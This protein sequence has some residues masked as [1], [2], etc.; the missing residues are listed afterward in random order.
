MKK[1]LI[2]SAA[3]ALS[4]LMVAASNWFEEQTKVVESINRQHLHE[5]ERLKK[6]AKINKWLRSTITPF[7]ESLPKDANASDVTLVKFFDRY[8]DRFDFRVKNYIYK[9]K[10]SH[11]LD[12]MFKIPR[13]D[14]KNLQELMLLR[15]P[16]GYLQY[17]T[18]ELKE[19]SVIGKLRIVQPLY[20]DFN[21]SNR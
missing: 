16:T 20:G 8:A 5:I 18:F 11:N 6:I 1:L 4:I 10:Y 14:K 12:V 9:D 21:V 2:I 13:Y 15:Y 7:I 19:E 17:N 3:F